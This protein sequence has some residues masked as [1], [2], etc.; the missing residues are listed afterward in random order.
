MSKVIVVSTDSNEAWFR[1]QKQGD[2]KVDK[3]GHP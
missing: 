1:G 3:D 2:A